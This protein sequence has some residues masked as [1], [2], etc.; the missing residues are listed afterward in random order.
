MTRA[1]FALP[2]LA[3]ASLAA[4]GA[5]AEREIVF[6][7]LNRTYENLVGELPPIQQGPFTVRLSSPRQ[8]VLLRSHRVVL[9]PG[10]GGAHA[11]RLE[12]EILGKGWLVGD[13]EA[14]GLTTRLQDELQVPPQTL[15]LDGRAKIEREADGYRITPLELPKRVEVTIRSGMV[16]DLVGWCDR[17]SAMPFSTLDCSG[18]EHALDK[19]PV[20]LPP[21]GESY[22][23]PDAELRPEDRAALDAY[24]ES[25]K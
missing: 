3:A 13:V 10:A 6:P 20:P 9:A 12:L 24:L 25:A 14:A 18:L 8:T 23:L 21:A 7:R 4:L 22:L 19:V 17:L 5:A 16:N 1:R 15:R 11:G 2:L